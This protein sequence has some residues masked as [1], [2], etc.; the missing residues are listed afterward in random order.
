MDIGCQY[1]CGRKQ[2]DRRSIEQ[3]RGAACRGSRTAG[4]ESLEFSAITPRLIGQSNLRPDIWIRVIQPQ[5]ESVGPSVGFAKGI[6][7]WEEMIGPQV[8]VI[9]LA[10]GVCRAHCLLT[11]LQW[12]PRTRPSV[13]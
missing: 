2:V 7:S 4:T 1:R 11:A 6:D 12:L 3:D 10:R 13:T 8:L 9:E 5:V